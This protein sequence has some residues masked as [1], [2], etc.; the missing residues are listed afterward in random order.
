VRTSMI[1]A[2]ADN[3]VIG[4]DNDL[5]WHLPDDLRRFKRLTSG[6]VVVLGRRTHESIVARLGR[7][8]PGRISVVVSRTPRPADGPVIFQPTPAAALS[9]ARAIEEFA[10][11]DEVF[12]AGGAEI[13]TQ[14]LPDVDRIYLTRVHRQVDGD[15]AMPAGWLDGFTLAEKE[16]GDGYTFL[17]YER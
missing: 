11:R 7:P 16:A 8:M 6:H 10:G 15:A 17:T 5:P 3:G 4:R 1:L 13:Y 12:V 9:V 2:V 14:A